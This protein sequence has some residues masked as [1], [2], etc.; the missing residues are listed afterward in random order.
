MNKQ[1]WTYKTF[2]DIMSPA[3]VIRCG[4][5][6]LPVLSI[7]MRNGIVE[8]NE[9]FSK[10]IA[11][12]DKSNYKVVTNG[13]LV[14]AFPIDEGLLYT[15]DVVSEGI[16]SPAYNIW[17]VDYNCINRR[18]LV[19]FFHS[20]FAFAYY[21]AKLKGTTQRRRVIDKSDLLSMPIPVP[22]IGEQERIV[23]ELDLLQGIIEKKKEQLKAYDQLAQSIFYTMFGDPIDN[24]KGWETKTV[25][26]LSSEMRYGTSRPA[27]EDGEFKY[28]RMGNLTNEGYLNLE[29]LKRISIP[30]NEIDKC[31]V[32]KG[33]V[34][35]NRT[36]SL[37]LIGK[38]CLFDLDEPMIIA[39]YL[40]R[41]RF[42]ELILPVFFT[43]L[44]NL[45][46]IKK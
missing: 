31:V 35:F 21:K 39:G 23:A 29:D 24:P 40:I 41:V 7:T 25:G 20:S 19:T 5:R 27:C 2:G 4:E 11:S 28:L 18:F 22:P 43:R 36:N 26:D 12:I 10:S 15:Q 16:M 1:D 14:I 37:E 46:E 34:L 13:Q 45:Q 3:P 30:E 9:R 38:T 32:R 33:D 44:F 42:K 6:K 8:Q 17:D